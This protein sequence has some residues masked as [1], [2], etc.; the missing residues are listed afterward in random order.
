MTV[1]CNGCFHTS[2]A[3]VP[4]GLGKMTPKGFSCVQQC[5][6]TWCEKSLQSK[7]PL[8]NRG[9]TPYVNGFV[10][11]SGILHPSV[12]KWYQPFS[13]QLIDS[14]FATLYVWNAP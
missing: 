2:K 9:E 10:L 3:L 8:H 14:G 5:T 13:S 12:K 7:R 1:F 6:A 11:P 4:T